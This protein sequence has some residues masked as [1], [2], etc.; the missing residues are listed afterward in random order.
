MKGKWWP[1]YLLAAAAVLLFAQGGSRVVTAMAEPEKVQLILDAGH[2]GED[3]GAL[4]CTGVRESQLNLDIALR[5]EDLLTLLGRRT[6]MVRRTD[7]DLS[8][9]G[10]TIAR[11][12]LSDLKQRVALC[13]GVERGLLVSIHQNLFPEARY[14]GPQVF[15]NA[16]GMALAENLQAAMNQSLGGKRQHKQ[17]QGVYLMERI[18]CPGV[19][20][21]CGFL[22]NPQEEAK[23]RD[24]EYQKKMAC[25]I[26]ATLCQYLSNT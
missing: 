19:L 15:C 3:G 24:P 7:H 14:S 9:E 10:E 22:S 23:L 12:K 6:L 16:E 17:S 4:S 20:V 11:R 26:G 1:V 21:E 8:R 25:V 18:R 5:L 2:G 13:N